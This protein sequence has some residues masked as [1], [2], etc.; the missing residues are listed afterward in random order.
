MATPADQLGA[1]PS[2]TSE[3]STS[4]QFRSTGSVASG[5]LTIP[6]R[7]GHRRTLIDVFFSPRTAGVVLDLQVGDRVYTRIPTVLGDYLGFGK[8]EKGVGAVLELPNSKEGKGFL[9]ALHDIVPFDFPT[10]AQD[11]DLTITPK[12]ALQGAALPAA[13]T[14]SAL[15][16]DQDSGDVTSNAVPGGSAAPKKLY[17]NMSTNGLA[18]QASG[19]TALDTTVLPTGLDGLADNQNS[20]GGLQFTGYLYMYDASNLGTT[21]GANANG[22]PTRLHIQ[23]T[24]IEL[25]TV[26]DQEGLLIDRDLGNELAFDSAMWSGFVPKD[27]YVFHQNRRYR[28]LL[29]T[30]QPAGTG[31]SFGASKQV[32]IMAGIREPEAA[33][34]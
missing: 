34:A 4:F 20:L 27:P 32:L 29:D 17:F 26:E 33:G 25:F 5:A 18:Q 13:F 24:N 3:G 31:A 2:L 15:Y 14:V 11:E 23:D 9:W 19:Q 7:T 22:K 16:L 8:P 30:A 6:H 28:F 12:A 10:A 21:T 1:I